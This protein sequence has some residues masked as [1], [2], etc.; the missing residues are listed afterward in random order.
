MRSI[1]HIGQRGDTMVEVL[2][3]IAVVS[4]VLAISYSIMNR[5]LLTLRDNQ[6]RTAAAK[7]SQGQLE[8]LRARWG[9]PAVWNSQIVPKGTG[10]FCVRGA[11]LPDLAAPPAADPANDVLANYGSCGGLDSNGV[12]V[13][14]G[15]YR[16]AVQ[17]FGS[18]AGNYGYRIYVRWEQV[19]TGKPNQMITVYRLE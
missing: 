3:A 16:V 10:A 17:R 18:P 15:I 19:G 8:A 4:S 2:L 7:V 12:Q 13:A 1:R 11:S 9:T 6:E 14:G 5:N